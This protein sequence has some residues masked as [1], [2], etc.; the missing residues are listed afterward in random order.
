MDA[1]RSLDTSSEF[2][3][4]SAAGS[5]VDPGSTASRFHLHPRSS[6]DHE[7]SI[8]VVTSRPAEAEIVP[9]VFIG[10]CQRSGS[11][12]LDRLL[13]QLEGHVSTGELVHLWARGVLNDELCGCGAAFLECPFWSQVGDVGFGGWGTLDI[14]AVLRLKRRVDRNRYIFFMLFP[15][16]RPRYRRDLLAYRSLLLALYRAIHDVRG[17]AVVVDSSKHASTAFLLRGIEGIRLHV[18]HLVRDSRGVAHSLAKEVQRPEVGNRVEFMHRSP[19]WRSGVE[20]LTFNGLFHLLAR[21]GVPTKRLRYED[22]VAAP[23]E[24][25]MQIRS[26]FGEGAIGGELDFVDGRRIELGTDHTVAGNPI[27]FVRDALELNL[28]EDWKRSMPTN[29]RLITSV[30]TSPLLVA[31]GY[32]V[33]GSRLE[34]A[35]KRPPKASRVVDGGA[36]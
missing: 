5:C 6:D 11:T 12:L 23:A 32:P 34:S 25:L 33:R 4:F 10:G 3:V 27:R 35:S 1:S 18:L 24:R 36:R 7:A 19:A 20:W 16:L 2:H 31:Y 29:P 26:G 22:L 14:E 28:D 13:G 15:R 9:V 30:L 21:L 8:G 17:G